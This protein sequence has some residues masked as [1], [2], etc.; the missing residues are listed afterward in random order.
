VV[1][2]GRIEYSAALDTQERVLA[3]RI[4]GAIGDTLLMV[5]HPSVLTI[6]KHADRTNVLASDVELSRR[7]ISVVQT[8]RGG[9]VTYHG[10]GQLVAYPIINLRE[11]GMG[12]RDYVHALERCVSHLLAT[13]YGISGAEGSDK[14]PGVWLEDAKIAAIGVAVRRAVTFHGI[15]L[16]ANVD[17]SAFGL[18]VPCGIS[19]RA[20]TSIS[21]ISGREVDMGALRVQFIKHFS[22][23]LGYDPHS[24]G[25]GQLLKS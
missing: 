3:A 6:G 12:V 13:E 4:D 23:E 8:T 17:L 21:D 11:R 14:Y 10:P 5:E 15:A 7:G 2:L 20:V 22:T 19:G 24:T 25:L 9:D 16:N 1:D 18:I